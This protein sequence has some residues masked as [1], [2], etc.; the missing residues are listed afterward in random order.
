MRVRW[1]YSAAAGGFAAGVGTSAVSGECGLRVGVRR[2]MPSNV[3]GRTLARAVGTLAGVTQMTSSSSL[4][5]LRD[6]AIDMTAY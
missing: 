5:R 1:R 6:A 3:D 4:D 2:T